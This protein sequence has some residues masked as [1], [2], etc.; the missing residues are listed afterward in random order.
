LFV[1][2][3]LRLS[4]ESTCEILFPNLGA[5]RAANGLSKAL[6]MARAGLAALGDGAQGLVIAD[7]AHIWLPP[8]AAV[9]IDYVRH[10]AALAA[11]LRLG[12]GA[13]RDEALSSA[14][15]AD[16]VLLEDEPYADWAIEPRAQLDALR[17]RAS[18]ELARDRARGRGRSGPAAVVEAW[19]ACAARDPASEEAASA[20]VQVYAAQGQRQL[21]AHVYER[22]RAALAELG[23]HP[24]P[25]L[26]AIR[27][28]AIGPAAGA[29]RGAGAAH[30]RPTPGPLLTLGE[31][32]LVSVLFLELSGP[33]GT[34]SRPDPEDLREVVGGALAAVIA[35][36][37]GMGGTVTSLSGG[38]LAALFG[39]P[40]NHED[41]PER[42]VR[43]GFR[44]LAALGQPA[45]A[46]LPTFSARVGIETGSAVVGPIAGTREY[47]A[48]GEVVVAAAALQAAA[49]TGAVLVG[50]ATR[51]ATED[52][53]VWG[54]TEEVA[55]APTAGPMTATYLEVPKAR[56]PAY[57]GR[58]RLAG[59][60]PLTGR[61]AETEALNSALRDAIAGTGS[62]AFISGDPGLGKTRLVQECRKRFMA[63]VGTGTGRLPLWLE[64]RCA[65]Y[66]SST[67]YGLYQQLLAAWTGVTP[68]EG[69]DAM[70]AALERAIKAL[71]QGQIDLV[72]PLAHLMGLQPRP[73]EVYLNRLSPEGVQR[74]AFAA[75]R[76]VLTRLAS[77]GPTVLVL[78]DLHWADHT[79]LRLTQDLAT[80]TAQGPLFILGTHRPEPDP[81]V[82]ALEAAL[83][84]DPG[85]RTRRLELAPLDDAAQ[86]EL[87]RSLVGADATE[88]VVGALCM[89][90]EGNP[91]FLEERLSSLVETGALVR[92]E[93]HWQLGEAHDADVPEVLERL[94][95]ARVDRL[96]PSPHQA[97]VAAS[98]LGPYFPLSA[99]AAVS[100][101]NGELAGA[102]GAL[103]ASGLLVE[104]SQVPE[105]GYR[106]RHALIQEATYRGLLRAQRRQ[107]HARAAWGLES[108][109][110]E[111]PAEVAA[112]LGHHYAQ[113]GETE[114]ALHHLE[115]AGD[116]AASRFANDE[117]VSSY[118]Y[119][120]QL[121]DGAGAGQRP[122][123]VR[124]RA[125]LADVLARTGRHGAAREALQEALA[126]VGPDDRLEAARLYSRLG[127]VEIGGHRH[128]A[129]FDAFDAA[130][131]LLGD[132][133][134]A[135]GPEGTDVWMDVQ[136]EGRSVLHYWR[137]EPEQAAAVLA[138]VRPVV[139][140]QGTPERRH[141]F[142]VTLALQRARQSRYRVDDEI[143]GYM[144]LSLAA[145]DQ[146]AGQIDVTWSVFCL[147]FFLLWHGDLAEAEERLNEALAVADKVGDVVLRARA[148]CYLN[149]TALRRH[150]T[151]YVRDLTPLALAAGEV[152]GYPEYVAS[153]KAASSWL[154]WR[155]Q[156]PDD[157]LAMAGE[158]L[159]IWATS[160]VSYSWYW[161]CLWPLI[162]VR[163]ERG[164]VAEAVAASRQLLEPPQQRLPD[165][166]EAS[167][168][169]VG[170]LWDA[171]RR[172]LAAQELREALA[173]AEAL[174]YA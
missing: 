123:S 144:R 106:F 171:G 43:A 10:Q 137:N 163:L 157:A 165:E 32:R 155:D 19:E 129:A 92:H 142:F 53:F 170:E 66:A 1:S 47:G 88:P 9:E 135:Y 68:E 149:V 148:L 160:V 37:E 140:A 3:G 46:S 118:R 128:E 17:L 70:R 112:L 95:R 86:R 34:S 89:S 109:W 6:A 162:A 39:A 75:V 81:G 30:A 100:D 77:N 57:R 90:V 107:L 4:R 33:L 93:G 108:A 103:C 134:A 114:R 167:L 139:E 63:W 40:E 121:S 85:C 62:V 73:E 5:A 111:R 52:L 147:G 113:A 58:G 7:R 74:A 41:D 161:I 83:A 84:A 51:A 133:P 38:G 54:P 117:A 25:A 130:D 72:G 94:I 126:M 12:P 48:L 138:A 55:G 127:R 141:L 26:A 154:A 116:Y 125:R 50:P 22:C 156:R 44:A 21:A 29:S 15:A 132:D 11:A 20:L 2:P 101:L 150:D 42:A 146:V 131:Q 69:D 164:L 65:S 45:P 105:P 174:G 124:L 168:V 97:I 78:E 28:T 96:A 153:A 120:L 119:A 110:A 8:S 166:L 14:L 104:I 159:D 143:L 145:A 64:G 87:A 31:R 151:E 173:Q 98:V 102:V 60:A 36:I 16:A 35:E 82:T 136:V 67:P 79:S 115:N 71:F 76:A 158:A 169:T 59:Q 18:L 27:A 152:A 61:Q 122:V 49:K 56:A 23:L 24:S 80:L 172:E 91:L 13:E 99:L